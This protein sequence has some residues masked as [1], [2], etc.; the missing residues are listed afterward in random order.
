MAQ[1]LKASQNPSYA[2]QTIAQQN[3]LLKQVQNIGQRYGG[4]YNKAFIDVCRQNG[5]DPN[6]IMSQL[7]GLV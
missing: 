4:D 6:E 1:A 5:I 7:Q 3:P 2:I